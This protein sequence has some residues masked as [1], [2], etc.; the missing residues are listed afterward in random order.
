M[1]ASEV[2][3]KGAPVDLTAPEFKPGTVRRLRFGEVAALVHMTSKD[4]DVIDLYV[5]RSYAVF[6]WD[7]LIA[8]S[9]DA[10]RVRLFAPQ[11]APSA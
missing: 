6:A 7:W 4:P 1:G 2:I 3:M 9:P 5:F 8:T 11:P 10:A